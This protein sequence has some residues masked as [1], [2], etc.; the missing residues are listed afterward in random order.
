MDES[1]LYAAVR[2]VELNPVRA[3]LCTSAR[4]W[5]W[6]SAKTHLLGQDDGLVEVR[7]MLD[8]V[9]D[10]EHYLS[11]YGN[12]ITGEAIRKHS[13]TGR[14]ASDDK[15]LD[16]LEILT[17]RRLKKLKPGPRPGN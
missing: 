3:Q 13:Q 2:Y 15:F 5:K 9:D 12:E 8:R 1:H 11:L 6:S 17:R 14:P 7:P 16:G 4:E 10:W